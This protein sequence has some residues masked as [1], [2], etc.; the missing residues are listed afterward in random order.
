MTIKEFGKYHYPGKDGKGRLKPGEKA[1]DPVK[2][3]DD[4]MDSVRYNCVQKFGYLSQ[5][6]YD[7]ISIR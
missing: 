6:L 5:Q 7:I 1:D 4:C 3:F 2:E